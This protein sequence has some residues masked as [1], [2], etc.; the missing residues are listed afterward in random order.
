MSHAIN[1]SCFPD[2]TE[3]SWHT[4][5]TVQPGDTW[6]S[7]S[8]KLGS[9][10]VEK[11]DK[12][13][14]PSQT[15]TLDLLCGCLE[16]TYFVS[17]KIQKGDT[18]F[19]IC[20]RFQADL[21]NTARLNKLEKVNLIHVGDII[22]IPDP[23]LEN[24]TTLNDE[25]TGARKVSKSH[26]H[27]IIVG[28][29][30]GI[31]SVILL[32]FILIFW[33]FYKRKG[34]EPSMSYSRRRDCMHYY[35][36]DFYNNKSEESVVSSINS[37]KTT[38]FPYHEICDATS[39]FSIHF[40][41]GQGS[42]G[43]VYL[44]KLRGTDVAIK[45]MKNTKSKEFLSEVN[46]LCNVHHTNLIELIGYAAGGDSLFLVYEYAQNG[47]L[48]DHLRKHILKECGCLPWTTR[49]QIALDAAKGLEHIHEH[50]KPYY[51]HRDVKTSNIL[52]DAKF[53]AKIAD[54]GLVKLL[55]H[56]P[57]VGAAASRIVGTFGYLAPEYVR[58]G[59]VT[60]KSD[61]YS[62]G[63]V[64]MELITGQ[65][66]LSKDTGPGSGQ[67]HEHRS[68]VEYILSA[69]SDHLDSPTKLTKCI[70]PSLTYYHK[71]SLLQM[72]L[73]SKDCVDDNRNQRPEMSKVVLRLSHILMCSREWEDLERQ[74]TKSNHFSH[75]A[76]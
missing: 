33:N 51:V 13:L 48:S 69:L 56:S 31:S 65:P 4:D 10:V 16:S 7:V 32:S 39:N 17:Y 5:Y 76:S 59:Y 60:T 15:V 28:A 44:G 45:Q 34:S 50:T 67:Y 24:L 19:T 29:T 70:D 68:L 66:A 3:F 11:P 71:E 75:L 30:V 6:E 26:T 22:F 47:A 46:I 58:D 38:V 52:L 2:H 18:L 9:F 49:V 37:D 74:C 72:A 41:I 21:N 12:V 43:S 23:G 27:I 14:I 53:R 1:C 35:S 42:Y 57:E 61:V 8:L 20:S 62:F 55:E 40:K 36:N 25:D 54:F 73:L 63:V 64:L